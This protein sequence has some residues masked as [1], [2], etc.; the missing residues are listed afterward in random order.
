MQKKKL[1]A[2]KLLISNPILFVKKI[3][4][5]VASLYKLYIIKDEFTVEVTRWFKDKG[6]KTFRLNYPK[7]KQ[8][9]VVFDL[10]GYMGDFAQGISEKYGCRIYLFEPHPKFYEICVNRFVDNDK[11]ISLNYGISD[12]DGDFFLYDN[13]DGSSILNPNL[14]GKKRLKCK[15]KDFF[16]VLLD[17]DIKEIDLMKINIEGGE[18]PLLEH[19]ANNGKL[20]LVNEY[21]IQ[22]HNFVENSQ[23]K[24]S[25]IATH[26]TK[27]HER[28]WCY[29]FVWENWKRK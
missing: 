20:D 1:Q 17:L 19:I 22:F 14:F 3:F 13:F 28:T 5:R 2:L 25:R 26:L 4:R 7:L 23:S 6:D 12:R 10:G 9:S 24:R 15:V 29:T 8:D 16:N 18:Y 21:Q 27:T 11:I